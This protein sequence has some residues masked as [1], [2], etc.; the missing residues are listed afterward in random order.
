MKAARGRFWVYM[1]DTTDE[2]WPPA[3][4]SPP[5]RAASPRVRYCHIERPFTALERDKIQRRL[6]PVSTGSKVA[7]AIRLVIW[8][9]ALTAA[10][11]NIYSRVTV[12]GRAWLDTS[13]L[14]YLA[15]ALIGTIITAMEWRSLTLKPS[16]PQVNDVEL[17][18]ADGYAIVETFVPIRVVAIEWDED[19]GP[20]HLFDVDANR[21]IWCAGDWPEEMFYSSASSGRLSYKEAREDA[22]PNTAFSVTRTRSQGEFLGLEILGE[23]MEPAQ[24][25]ADNQKVFKFMEAHDLDNG[26]FTLTDMPLHD[27]LLQ[28]A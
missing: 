4:T 13:S 1:T 24:F 17:V 23:K 20:T 28:I 18:L 16:E 9:L 5:P 14:G 8:S 10:T 19:A 26:G 21:T 3:P 11:V 6:L 7:P 27:I 12:H 25:A 2:T 15:F 22:W